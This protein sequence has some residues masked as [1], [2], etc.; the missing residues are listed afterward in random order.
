MKYFIFALLMSPTVAAADC[1]VLLHGLARS[2]F[3]LSVMD[4][5]LQANGYQTVNPSYPSTS[6]TI[7]ELSHETVPAAIAECGDKAPIH[8]I[9]HSMGGILVR[10]WMSEHELPSLGHV[11]M[12]S[13]PNKGSELV[14]E[15]SV[16]EPFEW[17]NGPAGAQLHTRPDSVPNMLGPV[18][19]S[20]GVIAGTQSLNPVY[21]LLIPGADDGKVS[22]EST[23]I[24]G[25]DDH[26]AL[27]VTH[28]FMMN[29]P[30]VVAQ[31]MEFLETGAFDHDLTLSD[32]AAQ[33]AVVAGD[34]VADVANDVSEAVSETVEQTLGT[35]EGN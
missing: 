31:T 29:S 2:N 10:D 6:E 5:T 24:E 33:V 28:T 13:P 16:W 19:F 11:V 7:R 9:T 14:D 1:V 22:V 18:D 17:V 3:S 34:T 26:L 21:S 15:L 32:V 25:M 30:L 4:Q 8:F 12:L 23:K 20:L 35:S 27:P